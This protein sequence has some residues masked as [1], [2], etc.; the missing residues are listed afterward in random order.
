VRDVTMLVDHLPTGGSSVLAR[1]LEVA[2]GGKGGDPVIAAARL[3]VA[4]ALLGIVGA[5]EAG[6]AIAAELRRLG[7]DIERVARCAERPTGHIVHLVEPGGRRRYIEAIRAT[8]RLRLRPPTWPRAGA[9]TILLLSTAIPAAAARTAATAGRAAGRPCSSTAPAIRTPFATCCPTPTFCAATT[10]RPPRSSV[11]PSPASTPRSPPQ[12]SCGQGGRGPSSCRPAKTAN[13]VVG[14]RVELRLPRLTVEIINPSGGDAL[15]GTLAAP[16]AL[17]TEL[18]QAAPLGSA[19][20]ACTAARLRAQ[21]RFDRD[22]LE[23]LL[24]RSAR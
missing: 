22:T 12:A 21:P 6:D 3:G 5:D 8:D 7:V 1:E 10:A 23:R 16:L 4:E 24:A 17:G 9:D 2:A 19:A 18:P 15:I 13:V 14:D 11:D 20:A